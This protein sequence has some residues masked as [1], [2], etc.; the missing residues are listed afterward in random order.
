MPR[1]KREVEPLE[2]DPVTLS[3]LEDVAHEILNAQM[4]ENQRRENR[5]PTKEE[6]E[7]KFKLKRLS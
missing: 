7:E 5:S 2:C 6:A 1:R 3:E 4:P